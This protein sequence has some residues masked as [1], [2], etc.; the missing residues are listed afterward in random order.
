[1]KTL[2][3]NIG[4]K[5]KLLSTITIILLTQSCMKEE[6]DKVELKTNYYY[7]T[8]AQLNQTPYFTNPDFDTISFTS[9]KGDTL[10]F[11]KTKTDTSWYCENGSGNPNTGHD[12]DCYQT[13]HNTYITT[14]GNGS[15]DVEHGY[16]NSNLFSFRAIDVINVKFNQ[17]NFLVRD[18]RI[19]SK[20]GTVFFDG[21]ERGNRTYKDVVYI[22]NNLNDSISGM[23]YINK[24]EGLFSIKNNLINTEFNYLP[25]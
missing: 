4:M 10:T 18:F 7:L 11:V 17:L 21:I 25:K 6:Y 15:F 3:N 16:V 24:T 20:N 2:N 14:K 13:I 8:A 9:D 19:D 5:P 23:S 22:F 1:M 12:K